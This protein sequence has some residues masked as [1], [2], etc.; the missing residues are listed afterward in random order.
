M[1]KHVWLWCDGVDMLICWYVGWSLYVYV[2]CTRC[3]FLV[4]LSYA[5]WFGWL[6]ECLAGWL[7]LTCTYIHI[8]LV[9]SCLLIYSYIIVTIGWGNQGSILWYINQK[10][11]NG[12]PFSFFHSIGQFHLFKPTIYSFFDHT[13]VKAIRATKYSSLP[14]KNLYSASVK[15][16]LSIFYRE[17]NSD[18]NYF[19]V[20]TCCLF[21]KRKCSVLWV[22]IEWN[23]QSK[24]CISINFTLFVCSL[25]FT[26]IFHIDRDI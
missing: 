20:I 25:F 12:S 22:S 17:E 3:Y 1:A 5:L 19:F 6:I 7:L 2:H 21:E 26:S 23:V 13:N 14:E 8:S 11:F 4:P 10:S 18:V 9:L 24:R 15:I 16:C